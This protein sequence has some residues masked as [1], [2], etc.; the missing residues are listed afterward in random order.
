[1]L[2]SDDSHA[3]HAY[4][5]FRTLETFLNTAL[6]AP[7]DMA[8]TIAEVVRVNGMMI[9]HVAVGPRVRRHHER[10][11]DSTLVVQPILL[12]G[13]TAS[14]GCRPLSLRLSRG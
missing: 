1:M 14:I 6:P 12:T 9:L 11:G 10:R 4:V 5:F 13:E 7:R 2:L 8:S 3:D